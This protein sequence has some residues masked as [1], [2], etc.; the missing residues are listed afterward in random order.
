MYD[1]ENIDNKMSRSG[2]SYHFGKSTWNAI[3]NFDLIGTLDVLFA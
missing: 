1:D 2:N 3:F